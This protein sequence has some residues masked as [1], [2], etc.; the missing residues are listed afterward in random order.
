MVFLLS[1]LITLYCCALL[2]RW[3][4]V[5]SESDYRKFIGIS[6]LRK[7]MKNED[8]LT[9]WTTGIG[10]TRSYKDHEIGLL[11]GPITF[12]YFVI[13]LQKSRKAP[14]NFDNY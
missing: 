4:L 9:I 2:I 6:G 10:S 5:A 13:K 1:F 11:M 3:F 12:I 7:V 14:W 8:N